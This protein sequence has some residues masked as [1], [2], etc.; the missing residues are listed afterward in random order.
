[1]SEK[2]VTTYQRLFE[3]QL[4]HHYWLDDGAIVY[5]LMTLPERK[6]GHLQDYD[7][8]VFL[9]IT[10][11]ETTAR[12]L[13]SFRGVYKDTRLGCVVAL[14]ETVVLPS[15]TTLEFIITV[16]NAPFFNYTALTLPTRK[17]YEFYDAKK[18]IT[19]RYKENVPVWANVTGASRGAGVN[20]QLFLSREIPAR[21]AGDKIESLVIDGGALQQLTSDQPGAATRLINSTAA[22]LPVFVHQGD[23]PVLAPPAGISGVPQRG[24]ELSKDIT[25][26]VFGVIRLSATASDGDFS[27]LDANGHAKTTAPIFQLRFKNR[28]TIWKYLDKRTGTLKSSESDPLPLTYFGNAGTKQKA[29]PDV[30]KAVK[31]GARTEQLTSEIFI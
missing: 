9:A 8:R 13:K 28:S 23:I 3:I 24:I 20:K 31:N 12:L 6:A 30:V 22:N 2:A 10:Q 1:M 15:D 25:D 21:G 7:R 29:S 5:D 16:Q 27:F 17:I 26:D 18:K 11:T 14:P 4:L 19:Y